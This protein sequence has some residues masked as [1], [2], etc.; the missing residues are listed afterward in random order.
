MLGKFE[1]LFLLGIVL[2]VNSLVCQNANQCTSV[3]DD[4]NFVDC[5]NGVCVCNS[6]R[7]FLG[8]ATVTDKCTCPYKTYGGNGGFYCK[9]CDAPRRMYYDNGVPYCANPAE[10]ENNLITKRQRMEN[11]LISFWTK[12][13]NK[14]KFN[15]SEFFAPNLEGRPDPYYINGIHDHKTA[16]E[17]LLY[18][19][20]LQYH[21]VTIQSLTIDTVKNMVSNIV[22]IEVFVGYLN[23]TF[24]V[25]PGFGPFIPGTP[26]GNGLANATMHFTWSFDENGDKIVA[27]EAVSRS[28]GGGFDPTGP[29]VATIRVALR[30]Q[31]CATHAAKCT[32]NLSQYSSMNDCISFLS[33]IDPG[34]FYY[35][36]KNNAVCRSVHAN[37]ALTDPETHCEHLSRT[38]SKCR[39]T[40]YK[41]YYNQMYLPNTSPIVIVPGSK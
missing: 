22:D 35:A 26:G 12:L 32:G 6:D 7:G 34:S 19:G 40:P 41:S 31:L 25:F 14:A 24:Q 16:F 13:T 8:S 4:R 20:K 17:Y 29:N 2:G 30:Q 18:G 38:S 27:Y 21:Q 11:H 33:A 9:Q 28:T 15:S 10:C 36:W 39:D 5:V 3:S 37:L 1:I 23:D